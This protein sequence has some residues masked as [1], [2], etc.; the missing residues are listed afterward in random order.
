MES[1]NA[2]DAQRTNELA[3]KNL[4]GP[5]VFVCEGLLA[6][7]THEQKRQLAY[8]IH[9]L[10]GVRDGAWVTSDVPVKKRITDANRTNAS[11]LKNL[12]KISM[13]T[14]KNLSEN[15]FES[16]EDYIK[17]FNDLG[18]KVTL[19]SQAT[20]WDQLSTLSLPELNLS[21]IKDELSDRWVA[22]ITI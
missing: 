19:V 9:S 5:I 20:V 4:G 3:R 1:L 6:Y 14:G 21:N 16:K 15:M 2:L 11:V 8:N 10:L 13:N 17:F 18:L 12:T 7:L 22:T